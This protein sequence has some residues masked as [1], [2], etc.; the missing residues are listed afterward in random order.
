MMYYYW[1]VGRWV[2]LKR[3]RRSPLRVHYAMLRPLP[4]TLD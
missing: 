2:F 3:W 4:F 1:M